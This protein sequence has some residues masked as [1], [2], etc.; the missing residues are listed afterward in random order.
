M[1]TVEDVGCSSVMVSGIRSEAWMPIVLYGSRKKIK[2]P[3]IERST[4]WAIFMV[5]IP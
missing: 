4:H 3:K 1:K 2:P 5:L